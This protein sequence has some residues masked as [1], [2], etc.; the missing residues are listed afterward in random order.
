V[1]RRFCRLTFCVRVPVLLRRRRKDF[2]LF[3]AHFDCFL[4]STY[5]IAS[6]KPTTT[7]RVK[8]STTDFYNSSPFNLSRWLHNRTTPVLVPRLH[9]IMQA[10]SAPNTTQ[11]ASLTPVREVAVSQRNSL[12]SSPSDRDNDRTV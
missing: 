12:Y 11:F 6:R 3:D 8:S 9:G 5:D 10:D 1:A 4:Q 7:A 2:Q